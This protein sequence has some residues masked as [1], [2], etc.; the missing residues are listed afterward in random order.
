MY[1]CTEYELW[2]MKKKRISVGNHTDTWGNGK[3]ACII[4]MA[5]NN[6]EIEQ[7]EENGG[8]ARTVG[9]WTY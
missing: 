3:R 2:R 8:T 1:I 9:K 6:E 5:D 4:W 7:E